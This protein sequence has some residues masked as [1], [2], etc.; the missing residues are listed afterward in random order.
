MANI[1]GQQRCS[2]FIT[3]PLLLLDD[4]R[5]IFALWPWGILALR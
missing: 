1:C 5:I 4:F 3:T 2:N